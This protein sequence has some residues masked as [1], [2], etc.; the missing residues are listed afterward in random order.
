M[1]HQKE[2]M[3]LRLKLAVLLHGKGILKLLDYTAEEGNAL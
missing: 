2:K 3:V 1:D